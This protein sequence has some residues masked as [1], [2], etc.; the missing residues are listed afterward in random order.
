MVECGD[1]YILRGFASYDRLCAFQG[2]GIFK[3]IIGTVLNPTAKCRSSQASVD[4]VVAHQKYHFMRVSLF[5]NVSYNHI[6]PPLSNPTR[7][8]TDS[9]YMKHKSS[10]Q[11]CSPTLLCGGN[12]RNIEPKKGKRCMSQMHAIA[13]PAITNGCRSDAGSFQ[14]NHHSAQQA[15]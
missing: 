2:L 4:P 11:T 5:V 8:I 6:R 3:A 15:Q 10:Q 12:N 14:L 9:L 7:I 1:R 13:L